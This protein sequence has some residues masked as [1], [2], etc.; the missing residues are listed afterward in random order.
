MSSLTDEQR[1]MIEAN[2]KAAQ[3]KLAAKLALRN[4]PQQVINKNNQCTLSVSGLSVFPSPNV[5]STPQQ[6]INNNN[7]CTLSVSGLVVSPSPNGKFIRSNY[8]KSSQNSQSK[9]I[10]G[11]CEI[12]SKERFTLH[13]AYHQQLIDTIKTILSKNYDPKTSEW[14]FLI[15]Y[16]DQLMISIKP[17]EPLVKIEKL[18]NFVLKLFKNIEDTETHYSKTD[19]S[20]IGNDMLDNLYP[21]QKLGVQF[22]VSKK[23]RCIIADDM[24][25]GKTIQAIAIVK[26]YSDN[27]PLLIVCPSSMRYTWE[28][29]IRLRLP[30]VPVSSICVLSKTNEQ[31]IDP[32]VVITS[33][34]LMTRNKDML[35]KFKF[36]IIVFDESHSL[37][38]DKSAR[39]KV[40]L[41]LA[42]Q[43]KQCILLSGTPALSRPIELYCQIKAITRNNF[44]TPIE[45]GVRYCN[46]RETNFGWD[47]SGSSNMKELKII[48]ETHFMI[49]RLKSEVLKQLPQKIR[50]VVVLKPENIKARTQNMDDLEVMMTNT[51]LKKTEVRGAL[52]KYFNQ[53][54]EVKLP[55]ICDYILNLL[56]E[57]KKFLVFAHHQKVINGIC[58]VLENNET[59]YIRIDGKTSSEERKSVCDQFQ[60]EDMYRVAVL[61]ICAA[62]SGITLTA[63]KLVIFAELYWN[64]GILT[65]AEDRAHRIGQAEAVTIQYLLAKGTADD[66]IWPL[67]QFK[68]N[69]LNKAGLSKDNFKDDS[70]TV[71]NCSA[72]SNQMSILDFLND[73]D[74]EL[75]ENDLKFLDE[76]EESQCKRPRKC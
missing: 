27:F 17:L 70:T 53:T 29:E 52:L 39:T 24:G 13:V 33:Y 8:N 57:G 31:F 54:G 5:R 10:H 18:P 22:G 11:T 48:L 61:S 55:A 16:H 67:I 19:I 73:E 74:S 21:F 1:K 65:Q 56:K 42:M 47:F 14:S 37:K 72:K 7:K 6:V 59:Y 40:A 20:S 63:A 49:R 75:D 50:N 15:K 45:Y 35:L 34:D 76:V 36:G 44:I 66:H 30:N 3:A 12:I 64:P 51:S 9:P 2:K 69:V 4:T 41:S 32:A 28:E 23:G 60:S 46:G 62:N 68:L 25:L 43:S 58:D 71:I 26:Y 38:S